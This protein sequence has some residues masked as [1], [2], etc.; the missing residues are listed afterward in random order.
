MTRH[1]AGL[2]VVATATVSFSTPIYAQHEPTPSPTLE[3]LVETLEG[4]WVTKTNR[5]RL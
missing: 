4:V 3:A 2:I 5:G 1:Y